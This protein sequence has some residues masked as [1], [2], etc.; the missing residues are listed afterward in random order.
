MRNTTGRRPPGFLEILLEDGD[1]AV[2]HHAWSGES[3]EV[4]LLERAP[5]FFAQDATG[6]RSFPGLSR[7][8]EVAAQFR[9]GWKAGK[10]DLLTQCEW[11]A[12][13]RMPAQRATAFSWS[14]NSRAVTTL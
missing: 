3:W 11:P 9:S 2:N 10:P 7:L 12:T 13:R 8:A 5:D 6:N 4:R 1:V 14:A